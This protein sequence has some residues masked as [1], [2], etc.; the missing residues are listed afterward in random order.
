MPR[1]EWGDLDGIDTLFVVSESDTM[2]GRNLWI[3][4][5][6]SNSSTATGLARAR[7]AHQVPAFTAY[8]RLWL[9]LRAR[10]RLGR[11]GVACVADPVAQPSLTFIGGVLPGFA[12][13]IG[14]TE[15]E[16]LAW[17]SP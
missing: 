15:R 2:V 11:R 7:P 16:R 10:A 9:A 13:L 14:D 4:R 1:N 17:R 8:A 3:S 6:Q 5:S 12:L